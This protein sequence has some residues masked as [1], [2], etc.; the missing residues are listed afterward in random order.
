MEFTRSFSREF[1][2]GDHAE[3]RVDNRS[4]TVH[5]RGEETRTIRVDVEARLWGEVEEDADDQV[6]TIERGIEGSGN[7]V[8]VRAPN[9][10]RPSGWLFLF[11]R[12]P[13]IDYTITVPRA[14]T[15]EVISRSGHVQAEV[16]SERLTV[17]A[18]SGRVTLGDIAADVTIAVRSGHVRAIDIGGALSIESRSGKVQ[19]ERCQGDVQVNSRSG[20]LQVEHVG[21]DLRVESR[22][23][24]LSLADVTGSLHIRSR[25]GALRYEGPVNAPFDIELNSGA[26]LLALDRDSAFL[27]EAESLS[28]MVQSDLPVRREPGAGV[29][30]D[31]APTLRV[32]TYSGVIRLTPR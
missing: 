1:E 16:L 4:G 13:R 29:S 17:E 25:S 26:A 20:S 32:R 12:G 7:H 22:S 10:V 23:G 24:S 6:A 5:V 30:R 15:A 28:G 3:L 31:G 2:V 14:T 18:R 27:L 21:G 19:V 8:E 11:G 9:L